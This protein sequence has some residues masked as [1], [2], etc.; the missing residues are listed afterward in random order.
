MWYYVIYISGKFDITSRRHFDVRRRRCVCVYAA[1][2]KQQMLHTRFCFA[3]SWRTTEEESPGT[4]T[5]MSGRTQKH[6][7][8]DTILLYIWKDL[9]SCKYE[10]CT[11]WIYCTASFPRFGLDFRILSLALFFCFVQLFWPKPLINRRQIALWLL[12]LMFF[13]VGFNYKFIANVSDSSSHSWFLRC[14]QRL[15]W[16][17]RQWCG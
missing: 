8:K 5:H 13:V 10:F 11:I 1:E 12:L 7:R 14:W 6:S 16:E 3:V 4:H 9:S 2:M 15:N 17:C